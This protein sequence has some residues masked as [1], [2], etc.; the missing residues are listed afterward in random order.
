MRWFELGTAEVRYFEVGEQ[1][2]LLRPR[3]VIPLT[4]VDAASAS[5]DDRTRLDLHLDHGDFALRLETEEARDTWLMYLNAVLTRGSTTAGAAGSNERARSRMRLLLLAERRGDADGGGGGEE[6][7]RWERR[8]L[9][10]VTAP[11]AGKDGREMRGES[12]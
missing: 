4:E 6:E 8:S 3:D 2:E 9:A 5:D 7:R 10:A 12:I 1:S 11:A